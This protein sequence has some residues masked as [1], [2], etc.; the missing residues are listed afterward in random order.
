[1]Y[2]AKFE[3]SNGKIFYFG[4]KYGNIFDIDGLTGLDVS[5]S[6]S[7]GFNQVGE[8]VENLSIGSNML[9]ITGRLLGEATESKRK[10]LSVFA[11]FQSGRLT[12]ENKYFVDCVVKKTPIITI[13]KNDAK[14]ELVLVAPY[15][16][17]QKVTLNSF[18]VGDYA[19]AFSFPVN[20]ATPHIFGIKNPS[21]F[22]NCVNGGEVEAYYKLEFRSKTT[23]V[24]PQIINV[25][26]QEFLKLN[27]TVTSDDK[28]TVYRLGGRLIVEKETSGVITD[29]FS[30]LDEDSDL[31]YMHVGNN[32][33][34]ADADSGAD[35]LITTITFNDA[36]VG[37]YE[38]I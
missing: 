36:V 27:T 30:V 8:T 1:M 9:E 14:F 4:Y 23:T 15:P 17:W 21:A 25:E 32:L 19:P 37:V 18:A 13:D 26:T 10:M 29:A 28:F 22:I 34:K 3:N 6:M 5:V 7:Q 24:D 20:Y 38:G 35:Q 11:P 2:T 33:I 12:F 16:Y 31:M